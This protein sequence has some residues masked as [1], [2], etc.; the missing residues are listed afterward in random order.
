MSDSPQIN[1]KYIAM[2]NCCN[3]IF[4]TFDNNC[5]KVPIQ[6]C[7]Q[8]ATGPTGSTGVGIKQSFVTPN[9]ELVFINT[10]DDI[11]SAGNLPTIGSTGPTGPN[12][13]N[14]FSYEILNTE[15]PIS[16]TKNITNINAT[17]FYN[18]ATG[19][20]EMYSKQI[21]TTKPQNNITNPFGFS[22]LDTVYNNVLLYNNFIIVSGIFNDY[23]SNI[24]MFNMI[25]NTWSNPFGSGLDY[26]CDAMTIINDDLYVG[27][28][29][30]TVDGNNWPYL[31]KFDLLTYT[32][33][34]PF[35]SGLNDICLALT[36]IGT[37]LYVGGSFTI[38]D[39]NNYNYIAKFDTL[40]NTWSNPFGS[41][42][43]GNCKR[44]T[45]ID[46][47][48]YISGDFTQTDG[49]YNA[50]VA[51][52]DTLTNTWIV[53]NTLFGYINEQI[54]TLVLVGDDYYIGGNFTQ[55]DNNDYS[56]LA[57]FNRVTNTWSNPFGVLDNS[58]NALTL[59]GNYLYV[60]GDFTLINDQKI[61]KIAKFD[62]V[63][64]RWSNPFK[65]GLT[66]DGILGTAVCN[67]IFPYENSLI[68]AGIFNLFNNI[69]CKS[70]GLY[71]IFEQTINGRFYVIDGIYNHA[72][73]P[74]ITMN[75]NC[76]YSTS[77]GAWLVTNYS[78]N[79]SFY[80]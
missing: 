53:N 40:T 50:N 20:A 65:E 32:W 67:V 63:N 78:D 75:I 60:G 77:F 12:G 10:N 18:M 30:L 57:K 13:L 80:N 23:G 33:S 6:Q 42:L 46:N 44:M 5:Y 7:L 55:V 47:Y 59:V 51:V 25:S 73:N 35:G 61:N 48:I 8:L 37:D 62:I 70:I 71:T 24:A 1:I 14:V 15:G 22:L 68:V 9:G 52:F 56:Y 66:E 39:G 29:F 2:D 69:V 49:I 45:S 58:V 27:G 72:E 38:I 79:T 43:D 36:F 28:E 4:L 17:G 64:N 16:I 41:G 26:S 21:I 19:A 54:Y 76:L 34:N 11:I 3:L 74:N 31:A